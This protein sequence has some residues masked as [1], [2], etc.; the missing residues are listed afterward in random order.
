MN[1]LNWIPQVKSNNISIESTNIIKPRLLTTLE[2]KYISTKED[3]FKRMV[4]Y[5]SILEPI[6]LNIVNQ[7]MNDKGINEKMHFWNNVND[8]EFVLKVSSQ[9]CNCS[10]SDKM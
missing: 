3:N 4:L 9:N 6:Q 8:N 1:V 10:Q 2:L 5:F 7:T